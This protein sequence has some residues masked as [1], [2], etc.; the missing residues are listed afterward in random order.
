[1]RK[2]SVLAAGAVLLAAMPA[3]AQEWTD[4]RNT[5]LVRA[6]ELMGEQGFYAIGFVQ[7]GSLND[8]ATTQVTVAL[9]GGRETMLVGVCDGDCSDLDLTLYDPNGNQVAS[10]LQT[11]D[12]PIL[13][14]SS[15]TTGAY[16]VKVTMATCTVDP[17]RYAVQ[18]FTK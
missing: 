12:V 11:D 3:A 13:R 16:S 17:C 8:D 1:M 5:L 4:L 10:D 9:V 18:A 15:K 6:S 14:T 7:D 2:S